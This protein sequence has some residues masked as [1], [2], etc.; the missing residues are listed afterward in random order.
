M[1]DRWKQMGVRF[2]PDID[3]VLRTG[4]LLIADNTSAMFEAAALG[5]PV[6]ALNRPEYRRNIEH[7]LR[8]WSH[9]PGL[10][11]DE[12]EQLAAYAMTALLD[13]PAAQELRARAVAHAYAHVDGK[14]AE[15]AARAIE[16]AVNG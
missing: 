2:E 8:F 11:C 13:L 4:N 5:M 16:G 1:A 14:A 6:L 9:V 3:T 10:Q 15:H 12:P 7:G